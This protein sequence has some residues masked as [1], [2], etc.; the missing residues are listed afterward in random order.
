MRDALLTTL[1]QK[2]LHDIGLRRESL[3]MRLNEQAKNNDLAEDKE[4]EL[5]SVKQEY[6]SF[7]VTSIT[8]HALTPMPQ[9]LL[10]CCTRH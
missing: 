4:E 9:I 7:L 8:V 10:L 6:A 1:I 2:K 5:K 3:Q